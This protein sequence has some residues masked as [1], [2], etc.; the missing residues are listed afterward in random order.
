MNLEAQQFA[1]YM[2]VYIYIYI[3][4]V[5]GSLYERRRTQ[6][7]EQRMNTST[8]DLLV[9][10]VTSASKPIFRLFEA[11]GISGELQYFRFRTWVV[12]ITRILRATTGAI[13]TVE[14]VAKSEIMRTMSIR[15]IKARPTLLLTRMEIVIMI[16][17]S[18]TR[19]YTK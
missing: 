15:R 17:I 1:C 12:A 6:R 3:I 5:L 8:R 19:I 4:V 10:T 11:P 16:A 14:I 2:N 9:K 7:P 13:I 18:N